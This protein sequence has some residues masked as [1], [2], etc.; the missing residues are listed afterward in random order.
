MQLQLDDCQ[1]ATTQQDSRIDD[2][3][4]VDKDLQLHNYSQNSGSVSAVEVSKSNKARPGHNLALE[5]LQFEL[6][7]PSLRQKSMSYLAGKGA[8]RAQLMKHW[9]QKHDVHLKTG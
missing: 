9:S 2:V 3:R 5:A 1:G 8:T 4:L 7:P 6:P